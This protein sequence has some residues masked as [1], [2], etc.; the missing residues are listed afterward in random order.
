[1]AIRYAS[2]DS[3]IAITEDGTIVTAG[4]TR[5]RVTAR[6]ESSVAGVVT[7]RTPTEVD[8][9]AFVWSVVVPGQGVI[10]V[11][12]GPDEAADLASA[13]GGWVS[14]VQVYPGPRMNDEAEMNP[15]GTYASDDHPGLS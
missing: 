7:T 8:S 2:S 3:W 15:D 6:W 4:S 1:M 14:L 12:D 10:A 13:S 5:D 9:H 11:S